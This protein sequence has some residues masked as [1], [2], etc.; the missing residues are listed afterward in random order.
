MNIYT[1]NII[2]FLL[3]RPPLKLTAM[4]GWKGQPTNVEAC[5]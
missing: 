4:Y 2:T 5:L 1:P 3:V